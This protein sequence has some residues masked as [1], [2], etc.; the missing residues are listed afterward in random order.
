MANRDMTGSLLA[1]AQK[2]AV[3]FFDLVKIKVPH[4]SERGFHL[5]NAPFDI[6]FTHDSQAETYGSFGQ[7]LAL[8][9]LEEN[10]NFEI[11]NI[12]ITV[13][14]ISAHDNNDQN[15]ATKILGL[16]YIDRPVTIF[17]QFY[18]TEHNLVGTLEIFEGR[19]G[20]ATIVADSEQCLV[21]LTIASNWQDFD[22][23]NGRFTNENSQ[24]KL[25]A[26]DEGMQFAREVQKEIEWKP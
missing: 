14:G 15:F 25:F 7:L 11:P 16:N 3:T 2:Q 4:G 12:K 20:D 22:R 10:A 9:A 13:S 8:D 6:T 5:T 24:K 1:E 21:T 23:E 18:D 19:I 26:G 17:R